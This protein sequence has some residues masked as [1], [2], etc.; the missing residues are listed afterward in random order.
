[1]LAEN[2]LKMRARIVLYSAILFLSVLIS[3]SKENSSNAVPL[4]VIDLDTITFEHSMKGW[5]LYSWPNGNDWNYGL[6]QGTNRLKSYDEIINGS[7]SVTGI[8]LLKELLTKLP[9]GES[10]IWIDEGWLESIWIDSY[11]DLQLPDRETV[12]KVKQFCEVADIDLYVSN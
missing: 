4:D 5:E 11:Y 10:V 6:I 7:F 9:D 8:E 12:E 3:C 1:M 2:N